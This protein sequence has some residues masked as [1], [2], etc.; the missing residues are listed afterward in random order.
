MIFK[1]LINWKYLS[2]KSSPLDTWQSVK[3]IDYGVKMF[4]A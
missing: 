3:E 4:W 1:E 2:D